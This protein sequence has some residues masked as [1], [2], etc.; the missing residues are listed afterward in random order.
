MVGERALLE[1]CELP[2]AGPDEP[3]RDARA[4]EPERFGRR[5]GRRPILARRDAG[6]DAAEEPHVPGPRRLE[7]VIR[8][9]RDFPSHRAIAH[10][11]YLDGE[12]LIG[13][14]DRPLLAAPPHEVGTARLAVAMRVARAGEARDFLLQRVLDRLEPERNEGLYHRDDGCVGRYRLQR[15]DHA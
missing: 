15:R 4:R 5:L 3:P 12:L 13:E 11:R 14:K 8:R 7:C 6:Q 9:E 1:V 10:A 2:G